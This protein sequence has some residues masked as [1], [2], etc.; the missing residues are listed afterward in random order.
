MSAMLEFKYIGAV[1]FGNGLSAIF[2]NVL[3]AI[4]LVAFPYDPND[5]S[6]S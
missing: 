4:T 3:R 6:T 2:C 1:M 5:E